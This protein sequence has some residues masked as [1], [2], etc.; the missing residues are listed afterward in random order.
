MWE[1]FRIMEAFLA[2]IFAELQIFKNTNVFIDVKE[3]VIS[4]FAK[5]ATSSDKKQ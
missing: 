4:T 2:A 5:N 3:S 1:M